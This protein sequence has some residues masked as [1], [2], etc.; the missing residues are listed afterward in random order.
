MSGEMKFT[1]GPWTCE[2][3]DCEHGDIYYAIHGKDYKFIT[4]V[5]ESKANAKLIAAAP[6]MY[7]AL[8]DVFAMIDEGYL[9]RNT[10]GDAETGWAMKQLPFIMRLQVA[11]AALAKA[12]GETP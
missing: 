12:R 5:F 11:H 1:P 8:I 3:D 7:E 6:E 2:R 9:V 10:S 4:N